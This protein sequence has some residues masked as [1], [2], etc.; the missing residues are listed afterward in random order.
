[1]PTLPR[2]ASR[3]LLTFLG[4]GGSGYV[5]DVGVFNL[6]RAQG[7]LAQTD[8][9]WARTVAVLAAMVVTYA[10]NRWLTWRG[11]PSGDRRREVLLFGL[12]NLIGFGFSVGTLLISHDLLGLTSR[13]ADN[14]SAN[15]VGVALGTLFRFVAYRWLVFAPGRTAPGA[16]RCVGSRESTG[17][18]GVRQHRCRPRR[19]RRRAGPTRR[20]GGVRRGPG[21][22]PDAAAGG[23]RARAAIDLPAPAAPGARDLGLA[24]PPSRRRPFVGRLPV[25]PARPARAHRGLPTR[26][27][28]RDLDVPA[29]QPGAGQAPAGRLVGVPR[30]DVPDRH[31]SAPPLGGTRDRHAPGPAR[32]AGAAGGRARR[33]ARPGDRPDG[34]SVVRTRH[35]GGP[36]RGPGPVRAAGRRAARAG[37]GRFLGCRGREPDRARPALDRPGDPG[38]RL[39]HQPRPASPGAV[40]ARCS[41]ARLGARHGRPDAGVRR[42]RP[43][44]RWSHVAGGPP[45]RAARGDLPVL[46]GHGRINN[47]V[48]EAAG[49]ADWARQPPPAHPGPCSTSSARGPRPSRPVPASS[50]SRRS[51]P[52][53][54]PAAA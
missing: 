40:A 23:G 39:R 35:R 22:L 2:I 11:V 15:V 41:R 48:L 13:L 26:H 30:G 53:R 34:R 7:A 42:R 6:L 16:L 38:R 21:R 5:V 49:W 4:V 3:E 54:C 47:D 36:R 46:P 18:G 28:A 37:G 25:R 31:G 1:M 10:G 32:P 8:P 43:E 14:I 20:G 17:P 9:A 29:G 44:R 33:R 52:T 51:W 12:V 19:C 27:R 50:T 24:A 45:V